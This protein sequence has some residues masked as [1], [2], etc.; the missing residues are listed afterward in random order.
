[1][2]AMSRAL[3]HDLTRW[4]A[5]PAGSAAV[6]V[7]DLPQPDSPTR[8]RVSPG[9][10]ARSEIAVH[11]LH[12]A[13]LALQQA[14]P[15]GKCLTRS[16]TDSSA[17][18]SAA[19]AVGRCAVGSVLT[20]AP[21]SSSVQISRRRAGSMWQRTRCP[22]AVAASS[23]ISVSLRP[24]VSVALYGQRGW[25]AQPEGTLISEGG[26]PWIGVEP[27]G[28]LPVQPRHRAEQTPGVGVLRRLE[29]VVRACRTPRPCRRTSPRCRRRA[30]RPRP[31]RG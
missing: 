15:I 7:V 5:R 12:R 17:S 21:E 2:C 19:E 11:R 8:P 23:G 13:D 6:P 29:D 18:G 1:M 24:L 20:A 30:R 3:E 31:G 25:N 9:A 28:A 22:G 4:S 26:L 14:A 10:D 27:L 16:A